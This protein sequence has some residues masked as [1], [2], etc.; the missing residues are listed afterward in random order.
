MFQSPGTLADQINTLLDV[1][2]SLGGDGRYAC[3]VDTREV[4]FESGDGELT[5]LRAFIRTHAAE[6][7]RL[8]QNLRSGGEEPVGDV[9]AGWHEPDGF[10]LAFINRRLAVV[11]AC[12]APDELHEQ[13]LKPLK[14]LAERLF[15]WN[16]SYR[17]EGGALSLFFSRPRLDLVVV[18]PPDG[19]H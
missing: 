3:V 17:S 15:Q 8:P 2:R 13:A 1:L 16:P 6:L 14:A 7:F 10:F 18:G 5:A 19:S 9:F 11:V 12:P 4:H